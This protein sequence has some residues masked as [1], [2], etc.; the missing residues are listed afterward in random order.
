MKLIVVK[1]CQPNTEKVYVRKLFLSVAQQYQSGEQQ[2]PPPQKKKKTFDRLLFLSL[3][4]YDSVLY[5]ECFN[6]SFKAQIG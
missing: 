4:L 5:T 3:N 2:R 1:T 6:I